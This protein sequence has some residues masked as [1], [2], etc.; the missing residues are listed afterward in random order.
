MHYAM[1]IILGMDVIDII[2]GMDVIAFNPFKLSPSKRDLLT[3]LC[4]SKTVGM[5][6]SRFTNKNLMKQLETRSPLNNTVN[7]ILSLYSNN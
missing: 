4:L 2:L 5:K 7:D 1:D 3:N 6:T